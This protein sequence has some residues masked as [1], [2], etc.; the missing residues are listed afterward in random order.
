MTQSV[1]P[2]YD[3]GFVMRT[4]FKHMQRSVDISIG[5]SFERLNDFP[6]D[7]AMGKEILETLSVLHQVKKFVQE[8]ET[9][10]KHL[11]ISK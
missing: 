2:P 3:K 7:N 4:T 1:K 5:K 9:N 10:N 8:F 6:G 11:F